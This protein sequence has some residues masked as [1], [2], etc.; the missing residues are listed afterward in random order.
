M[1]T[2]DKVEEGRQWALTG[3]LIGIAIGLASV[4]IVVVVIRM[5]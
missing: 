2:P 1:R 5:L 4:L 3:R